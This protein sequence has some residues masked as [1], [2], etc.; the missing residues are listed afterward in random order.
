[1]R[2]AQSRLLILCTV[3]FLLLAQ[4]VSNGENK[5][6]NYNFFLCGHQDSSITEGYNV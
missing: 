3:V 5:V 6:N 4:N 2:T 1:M